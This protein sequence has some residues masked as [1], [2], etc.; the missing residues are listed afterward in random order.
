MT[1]KTTYSWFWKKAVTHTSGVAFKCYRD[2][3]DRW[4]ESNDAPSLLPVLE[5]D[6][7]NSSAGEKKVQDP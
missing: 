6:S 4:R 2:E 1:T 3:E 5:I 7:W